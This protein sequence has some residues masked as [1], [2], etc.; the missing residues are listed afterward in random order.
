LKPLL[1][2]SAGL[3]VATLFWNAGLSNASP[4]YAFLAAASLSICMA[5]LFFWFFPDFRKEIQKTI[6]DLSSKKNP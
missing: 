4:L 3:V 6:S 1:L 5:A 2:S